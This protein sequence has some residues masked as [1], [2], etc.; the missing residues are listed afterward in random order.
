MVVW[1]GNI[2]EE[3]IF[4]KNTI[5]TKILTDLT[6][7]LTDPAVVGS[8]HQNSEVSPSRQKPRSPSQ[9]QKRSK[10]RHRSPVISYVT[11]ETKTKYT[12]DSL[13]AY[14]RLVY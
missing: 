3:Y 10:S 11:Y 6:K 4:G 12:S 13:F 2:R 7:I 1:G 8:E 14:K 9:M 5:T